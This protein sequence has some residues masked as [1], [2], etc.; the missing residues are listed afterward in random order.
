MK[1]TPLKRSRWRRRRPRFER[2]TKDGRRILSGWK[3]KLLRLRIWFEQ[4]TRCMAPRESL[5]VC[6]L[7]LNLRQMQLHHISDK[8]REGSPRG[9]GMASSLRNDMTKQEALSVGLH[10]WVEGWCSECHRREH[11]G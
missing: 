11:R 7:R 8:D 5:E 2:T 9:R 3:Y 4:G 1:R 6:G 10:A